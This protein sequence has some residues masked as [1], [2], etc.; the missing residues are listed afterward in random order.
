MT[1][2]GLGEMFEGGSADMSAGKFS[3]VSMGGERRVSRAQTRERGSPSALAEPIFWSSP[4]IQH[5]KFIELP[6]SYNKIVYYFLIFKS[7]LT[8]FAVIQNSIWNWITLCFCF[9]VLY[10]Y[11]PP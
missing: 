5:S 2:K 8:K 11:N 1:S 6:E 10:M 4:T 3:L 9:L 7:E